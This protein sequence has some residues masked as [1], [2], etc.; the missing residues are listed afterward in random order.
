MRKTLLMMML[1]ALLVMIAPVAAQTNSPA[2]NWCFDGGPLAGRCDDPDPAV[3]HWM[4][5]YGFYRAQIAKGVLTANDIPEEYRIGVGNYGI[6][7]NADS[8]VDT[9]FA[10]PFEA[11]IATCEYG[12]K[13]LHVYLTFFGLQRSGDLI[14]ISLPEGSGSSSTYVPASA[15]DFHMKFGDPATSITPGGTLKVYYRGVLIGIADGL[16]GLKTCTDIKAKK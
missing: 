8:E 5:L 11:S 6:Q 4:W 10:Q 9:S 13:N 12:D 3:S 1:V 2:D 16:N 7:L 14:Q 15:V